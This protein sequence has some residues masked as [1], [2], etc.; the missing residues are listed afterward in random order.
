MIPF[1]KPQLSDRE[2]VS[3]CMRATHFQNCDY[4]FGN[5]FIWADSNRILI[6]ELDGFYCA[7]SGPDDALLYNFPA[8]EGDVRPVIEAL[9]KD[10]AERGTPFV[11][12]GMDAA[13][14][15]WLDAAFPGAFTLSTNRDYCDYIYLSER[16]SSLSG[17]KLHG[18]RNHINRFMEN[19]WVYEP[20]TQDNIADARRMNDEWCK[21]YNCTEDPGLNHEACAVK[22]AFENFFALGFTGGLLRVN[23]HVV[24]YT[25]G[26]PVNEDT[27]VVHIEKA[28]PDVQGAY[29]MI[30][31]QFVRHA[32]AN[33][34]YVNREEDLGDEGLR[35][36]KLSYYPDILLEK[37][38]AVQK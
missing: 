14:S 38:T 5:H 17:K 8:G 27:F 30:N 29:P 10:A 6:A 12:R 25:M 35:K 37:Y 7:A 36:A 20:I 16:L 19:D 26:E 15:A 18:K 33:Y 28:F 32:C 1:R 4:T 9:R 23:G 21:R 11:L 13:A 2:W 22:R 3:A 24:A 34:K 31:Q